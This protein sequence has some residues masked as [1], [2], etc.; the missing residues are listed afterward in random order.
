VIR[1]MRQRRIIVT[2]LFKNTSPIY[3]EVDE[4][5][6]QEQVI[7][8][9]LAAGPIVTLK[10]SASADTPAISIYHV[11][12]RA[13]FGDFLIAFQHLDASLNELR[14]QNVIVTEVSFIFACAE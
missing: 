9:N 4:T 12:I 2:K 14:H 8:E 1:R 6:I 3:P 5:A 11:T 10:I 7:L 13:E